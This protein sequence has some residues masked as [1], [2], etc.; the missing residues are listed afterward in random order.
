MPPSIPF[1]LRVRRCARVVAVVFGVGGAILG[2]PGCAG[3]QP[4]RRS[5]ERLI[6][7][8]ATAF[9]ASPDELQRTRSTAEGQ[10]G[11]QLLIDGCVRDQSPAAVDCALRARTVEELNR[12]ELRPLSAAPAPR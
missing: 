5:C 7:R 3:S 9:G 10:R 12:C 2:A 1:P 8:L 4:S 11:V 6:E